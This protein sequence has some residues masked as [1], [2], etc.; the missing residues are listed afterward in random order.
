LKS[1]VKYQNHSKY[2]EK[3]G[4][5]ASTA[6]CELYL[7]FTY[8]ICNILKITTQYY[9]TYG[10]PVLVCKTTVMC[11]VDVKLDTVNGTKIL[12]WQFF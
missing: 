9:H 12:N 5:S 8:Y 11:R 7:V 1:N 4:A 6:Q 10:R 2:G 3:A